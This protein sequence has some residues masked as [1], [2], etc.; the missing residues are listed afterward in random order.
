MYL[1]DSFRSPWLPPTISWGIIC[2]IWE[3][4]ED[5]SDY[6]PYTSFET[7]GNETEP[8]VNS[9]PTS[10]KVTHPGPPSSCVAEQR[11]PWDVW[12]FVALQSC[13]FW[14]PPSLG[15][16][17]PLQEV[18]RRCLQCAHRLVFTLAFLPPHS[19][20]ITPTHHV[21]SPL[22][23]EAKAQMSCDLWLDKFQQ[24]IS[25]SDVSST[26]FILNSMM[27]RA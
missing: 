23:E 9:F 12:T 19:G 15:V 11:H 20:P 27:F 4:T 22:A 2:P 21:L 10:S 17:D 13:S 14:T 6:I 8:N 7:L 18:T 24:H 26:P 3:E 5:P 25:K 1:Q 16:T